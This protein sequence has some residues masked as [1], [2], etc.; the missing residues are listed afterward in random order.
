[1]APGKMTGYAVGAFVGGLYADPFCAR[2]VAG[3]RK[4]PRSPLSHPRPVGIATTIDNNDVEV[5]VIDTVV[6]RSVT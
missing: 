6:Q 5:F 4:V 1:M 3:S 2:K